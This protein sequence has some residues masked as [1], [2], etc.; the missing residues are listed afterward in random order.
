MAARRATAFVAVGAVGSIRAL[1]IFRARRRT[2]EHFPYDEDT[3]DV[4]TAFDSVRTAQAAFW[5]GPSQQHGALGPVDRSA[6]G[7]SAST[8]VYW[9]WVRNR[10]PL[11]KGRFGPLIDCGE[12]IQGPLM[13]R[14][15]G[16]PTARDRIS[17]KAA[18]TS[19]G[20]SWLSPLRASSSLV[21]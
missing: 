11:A 2:R 12:L 3:F 13:S 1:V 16:G 18:R 8:S 7:Q 14:Y 5:L 21:K 19:V 6:A 15:S 20:K 9:S 10:Q 4:A 17:S